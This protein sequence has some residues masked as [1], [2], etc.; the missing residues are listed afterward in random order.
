A[1]KKEAKLINIT[2]FA[3]IFNEYD[4][5]AP[6]AD[7][8]YQGRRVSIDS[9][10]F[11]RMEKRENRY[12]LLGQIGFRSIENQSPIYGVECELSSVGAKQFATTAGSRHSDWRLV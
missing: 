6:A 4:S 12:W 8:K 11:G 3:T 9:W 7:L 5:N 1:P 10:E 2:N